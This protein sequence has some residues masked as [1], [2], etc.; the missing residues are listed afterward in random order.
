[1]RNKPSKRSGAA[2]PASPTVKPT[3]PDLP[4]LLLAAKEGRRDVVERLLAQG[5]SVNQ[6]GPGGE[7]CASW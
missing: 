6:K 3:H 1:M 7:S 5:T 4:P 2:K